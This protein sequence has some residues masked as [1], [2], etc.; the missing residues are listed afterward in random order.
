MFDA[1]TP[2]P[3]R[4]IRTWLG[5]GFGNG[6]SRTSRP[7]GCRDDGRPH[8]RDDGPL[9]RCGVAALAEE[10]VCVVIGF[11]V[12]GAGPRMMPADLGGACAAVGVVAQPFVQSGHAFDGADLR[13]QPVA[14]CILRVSET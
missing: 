14:A 13:R 9:V 5:P 3:S 11:P 12:V 6:T 10:I 2:Q 4:R 7:F 8:R 1:H